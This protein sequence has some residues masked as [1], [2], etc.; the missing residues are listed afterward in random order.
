[1]LEAVDFLIFT[2][3][4]DMLILGTCSILG[5]RRKKRV[6]RLETC[7]QELYHVQSPKHNPRTTC[8]ANN[9]EFF[10]LTHNF[11]ILQLGRSVSNRGS[12]DFQTQKIFCQIKRISVVNFLNDSK[13]PQ[14][15]PLPQKH[16][17]LPS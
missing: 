1:M 2:F 5:K 6:F 10:N 3:F 8:A 4:C 9:Q 12:S 16:F 11:L 17:R 7:P 15:L 13:S 14:M